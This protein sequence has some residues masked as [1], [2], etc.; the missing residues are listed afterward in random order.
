MEQE[1]PKDVDLM[2]KRLVYSILQYLSGLTA[3]SGAAGVVPAGLDTE[4]LEVAMQCIS[5]S[6]G[7]DVTNPEHQSQYGVPFQLPDIYNF[8]L[9]HLAQAQQVLGSFSQFAF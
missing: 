6:F 3:Q 1:P 2:H 7:V 9:L 4:G 5:S 8:G